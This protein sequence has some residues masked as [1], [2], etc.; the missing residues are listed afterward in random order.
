MLFMQKKREPQNQ[1][2][3]G[4]KKKTIEAEK[5]P[6]DYIYKILLFFDKMYALSSYGSRDHCADFPDGCGRKL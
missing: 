6:G 4:T 3:P 1:V 2:D 5:K